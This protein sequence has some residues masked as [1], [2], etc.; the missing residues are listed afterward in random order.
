MRAKHVLPSLVVLLLVLSAGPLAAQTGRI[1]GEWRRLGPDGGELFDLAVAP[2]D[3]NV[4]YAR[5][6][7]VYRSRNGGATWALMNGDKYLYQVSVDA[8]NPSLVYGAAGE[9]FRSLDGGATWEPLENPGPGAGILQLAAHPR[10]ANTVF[11]ATDE[12]LF[13]SAD[14]GLHW[15]AV[16]GGLP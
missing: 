3:P 9:A 11:A 14:A 10:I 8:V 5:S 2:G 15:K 1:P 4:V 12:G 6:Q 16:R 7:T 13:R